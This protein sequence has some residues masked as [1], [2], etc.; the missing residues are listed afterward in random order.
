MAK[1][2]TRDLFRL[3]VKPID[4]IM[5]DEAKKHVK[6]DIKIKK[7]AKLFMVELLETFIR[8]TIKEVMTGGYLRKTKTIT[9]EEIERALRLPPDISILRN[10]SIS[11]C[12]DRTF[13]KIAQ[14]EDIEEEDN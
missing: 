14:L 12:Y 11:K 7:E 1:K 3:A 6:H 10:K 9:A 5:R 13:E 4:E 2:S 8:D